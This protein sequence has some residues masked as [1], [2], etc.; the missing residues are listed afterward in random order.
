M[1]MKTI[2]VPLDGTPLAEQVLPYVQL[3]APVLGARVLLL[4]AATEDQ[5]EHFLELQ[6]GQPLD[7]TLPTPPICQLCA[8]TARCQHTDCYLAAQAEQLRA[9]SIETY[10][11]TRVGAPA[12]VIAESAE[13]WPDTLIAMATHAHSGLRRWLRGSVTDTVVHDTTMP[14]LLVRRAECAAPAEQMLR[15]I[16]VPLDGSAFASQALP[17]AIELAARTQAM[18]TLLWV[19]APSIDEYMRDFPT[20]ADLRR[21][22]SAQAA[23]AYTA[24]AGDIPKQPVPTTT[25]VVLGPTAETIAE[26]AE[27]RHA[28]LIV[29]ATHGYSG[30]Q[31]WLLGSASHADPADAGARPAGGIVANRGVHRCLTRSSKVQLCNSS[32]YPLQN[33]RPFSSSPVERRRSASMSHASPSP[34][35]RTIRWK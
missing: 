34:N 1:A 23:E 4:R 33:Q 14:L 26:E 27:R 13:L 3:L 10:G 22:L 31:R 30:L 19:A 20:E 35:F 5:Q 6:R 8:L 9:C 25:A 12:S 7:I 16:L 24:L 17:L 29:M 11:D 28:G 15:H 21:T 32:F 2:L 18:L